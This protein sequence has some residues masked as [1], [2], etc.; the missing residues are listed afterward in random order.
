[1]NRLAAVFKLNRKG[2]NAARGLEVLVVMLVLLVVLLA[3]GQEKYVLSVLFAVL[4]VGLS[5][6]GGDYGDRLREM[7]LV[8]VIGALLTALGFGLGARGWG[9]VVL[10][11]FVVTL[12]SG[13]ALKY[14]MHRFVAGLLLNVWFL[15]AVGLPA[16]YKLD[17]VTTNA[18]AQALAWL[19]GAALWIA[20]TLLMWLARGRGPHPS[21]VPEIPGS[22][23][24][25]PLTKP[26]I[27]FAIIRAV[28][29]SI[30]MAIA[31]GLQVPN[32][33]WMPIATLVAMK[34]SLEQSVLVA[35]QR[36]AGAIMGAALA[37]LVLLTIT[38]KHAL[39]IIIVIL[40]AVAASIRT[41]NYALYAAAIAGL[42]LI[43][44]DIPHPSN[45]AAEGRRVLFTLA[46]VGI[47]VLV[48]LL[49]NM[50]QKRS[51]PAAAV[52]T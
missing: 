41:V 30:S 4:F 24:P 36:L 17:H 27:L 7:A 42:V 44:M 40:A 28:A 9:W 51:A 5:D 52:A 20:F 1:M 37:A 22:I 49:A 48:M 6:P 21:H 12:L 13:L 43:G 46:G 39:E 18:W 2:L 15:I 38:N 35:E 33:Y 8:G 50:L 16:S 14:G 45:F 31:F 10:A 47:G 3:L 23:K 34:P 11:V 29:L 19:I 32:A 26:V 25:I